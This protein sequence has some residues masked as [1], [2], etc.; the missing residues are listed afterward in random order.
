LIVFSNISSASGCPSRCKGRWWHSNAKTHVAC[1]YMFDLSMLQVDSCFSFCLTLKTKHCHLPS[2]NLYNLWE[3]CYLLV[4]IFL[5][6]AVANAVTHRFTIFKEFP[7][8]L[9]TTLHSWTNGVWQHNNT[10]TAL[11]L[12]FEKLASSL[13]PIDTIRRWCW[14]Y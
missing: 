12:I 9:D 4:W 10:N 8:L 1:F 3:P 6:F 7:Q 14:V 13:A 2:N 11:T 5:F